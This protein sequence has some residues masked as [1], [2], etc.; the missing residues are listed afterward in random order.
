MPL[1]EK[2]LIALIGLCVGTLLAVL[3]A[4]L[5]LAQGDPKGPNDKPPKEA[6][7]PHVIR[8]KVVEAQVLEEKV[9]SDHAPVLVVFEVAP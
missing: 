8:V 1:L 9:A 5:G 3:V 2:A 6:A 4:R 7:Y